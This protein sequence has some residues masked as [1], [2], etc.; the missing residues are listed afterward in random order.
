VAHLS[1]SPFAA[2]EQRSRG[3]QHLSPQAAWPSRQQRV[4]PPFCAQVVPGGQ[5]L[6]FPHSV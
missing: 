1:Q 3:P 2:L 5:Q 6:Y 4:S